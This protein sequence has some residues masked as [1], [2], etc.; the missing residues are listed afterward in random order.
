MSAVGNPFEVSRLPYSSAQIEEAAHWWELPEPGRRPATHL[1]LLAAQ[2]GGGGDDSWGSAVHPEYL[3]PSE[4]PHVLDV[5][6]S[7]L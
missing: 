4:Q 6:L 3:V 1:R 5:V 7:I 2:M